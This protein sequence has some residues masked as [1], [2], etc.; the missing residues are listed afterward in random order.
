MHHIRCHPTPQFYKQVCYVHFSNNPST[1]NV[2]SPCETIGHP[3]YNRDSSSVARVPEL[4]QL[5]SFHHQSSVSRTD[6]KA[7][8]RTYARTNPSWADTLLQRHLRAL[9]QLLRSRPPEPYSTVSCDL[10]SS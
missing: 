5:G 7:A 1:C 10:A 9:R 4:V 8:T 2:Y 6:Q 3:K